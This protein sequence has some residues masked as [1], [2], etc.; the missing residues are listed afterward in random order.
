MITFAPLQPL[1][2]PLLLSWLHAPHVRAWWD[3]DVPWTAEFIEKKYTHY[4]M[5]YKI[6]G[7]IKKLIY[8]FIIEVDDVPVGYI[9][10]YN[11]YDFSPEQGYTVEGLPKSLA[12]LDSYIG[13]EDYLGKGI[14]ARALQ[15]FLQEHVLKMFDACFVD[16]DMGNEV[17]IHTYKK[18]G[19]KVVKEIPKMAVMWMVAKS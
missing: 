16:P 8:A 18:A 15:L 1:H 19:L 11:K 4:T 7:A 14:G 5:G 13:E 2:F 12:A 10:Y 9:Q 6:L 3:K 17:A